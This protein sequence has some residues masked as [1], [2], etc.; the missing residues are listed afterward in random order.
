MIFESPD[1]HRKGAQ[2]ECCIIVESNYLG[3]IS[4]IPF[5]VVGFFLFIGLK[6]RQ[7]SSNSGDLRGRDDKVGKES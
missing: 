3:L 5:I 6:I 2:E 7:R 4:M 1:N